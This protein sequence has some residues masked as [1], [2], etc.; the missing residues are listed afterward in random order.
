MLNSEEDFI[1][2]YIEQSLKLGSYQG[3]IRITTLDPEYL[4]RKDAEAFLCREVHKHPRAFVGRD[5][6]GSVIEQCS[7]CFTIY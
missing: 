4:P 3:D 1:N 7:I 5:E 6:T 2:K